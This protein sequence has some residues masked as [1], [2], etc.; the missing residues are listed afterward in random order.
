VTD[1]VN[2]ARRLQ[3]Y[4][5]RHAAGAFATPTAA[6]LTRYTV[7]NGDGW[8]VAGR[9]LRSPSWRTDFTGRRFEL[10]AGAAVAAHVARE[11]WAEPPDLEAFDVAVTHLD[12]TALTRSLELAG[13]EVMAV[14]VTAASELIGVWGRAGSGHRYDPV[15]VVSI[16]QVPLR[17]PAAVHA[18]AEF[19][20]G[21]HDD[22]PFYSDGSWSS[23]SLRGFDA[24]PTWGVK[25]A[26]MSKAWHRDHP[27]QLDRACGWTDLSAVMPATVEWLEGVSWWGELERVRFMRMA[28]RPGGGHLARHS[29]ITDRSAGTRDGAITRWHV[30]LVTDPTIT[31][32]VWPLDGMPAT[33]HL[34]QGAAWYFDQRKPH[35]VTN[36]STVDRVH[37]VV[38]AVATP[39]LRELIV[40]R[41]A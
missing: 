25:P 33:L 17:V 20:A 37:L 36:P 6:E 27:G 41:G 35:A 7:L 38:D 1:L 34:G 22:Y 30:P 26:E 8:T 14:Q 18:E 32:T 28:A 11:P 3:T 19:L 4:A 39:G 31:M 40:R 23:L 16:A 29:D 24:D 12:D 9:R 10:P 15:D 21:W 13:R 5:K 2:A